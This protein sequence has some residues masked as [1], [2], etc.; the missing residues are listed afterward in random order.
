MS[1]HDAAFMRDVAPPD[2]GSLWAQL[3]VFITLGLL[4]ARLFR[5]VNRYAVNI[6]FWDQWDFYNATLFQHHSLWQMFKWQHGPHRQG[7][8]AILSWIIEPLFH[9]NSRA[10]AFLAATI[11]VLAALLALYVKKRLYGP[12]TYSDVLIP[13]LFLTPLEYE[14][15]FGSTNLSHGPLPLLLLVIYCL[16]WIY[17][18]YFLVLLINFLLIYTGFGFF[19]GIITPI[20]LVF[21]YVRGRRAE[22]PASFGVFL[23]ALLMALASLASFFIG[24]KFD[25]AAGCFRPFSAPI[26]QY[27][28]YVNLIFANF[29]GI[30]GAGTFP[31]MVGGLIV[32]WISITLVALLAATPAER[33]HP[34]LVGS[35]LLM[36]SLL[37][38]VSAALGR[39]CLGVET[40][41]SSRYVP[42]LIPA[43]LGL[44][45]ATLGYRSRTARI[46]CIV[47][48]LAMAASATLVIRIGDRSMM[49]Q[50][51]RVKDDWRQCYLERH[52]IEQCDTLTGNKIYPWPNPQL[53]DK[54]DYLEKN[55]LNLYATRN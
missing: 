21:D 22:Q 12:L 42:Y 49:A 54:L 44:Y 14:S 25:P 27:V 19:I 38:C 52:D 6:F 9:W 16:G 51:H 15:L 55:R 11:F 24:Y 53:K 20:L 33:G 47:A 1:T 10:E 4:A 41:Q 37:F 43:F 40:A 18:S 17:E 23:T 8:G 39:L 5:L 13:L 3:F 2:R 50:Y 34:K 28:H 36:F 31:T 45:F 7:V 32:L 35:A 26:L 46:V 30:R 48:L 29:T